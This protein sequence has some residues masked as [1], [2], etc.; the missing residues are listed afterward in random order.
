MCG[1]GRFALEA[2]QLQAAAR[3]GA[4]SRAGGDGRPR[5]AAEPEA[6]GRGSTRGGSGDQAGRGSGASE[7]REED[8][9]LQGQLE[10]MRRENF[11]PGMV[12]FILVANGNGKE[13]RTLQLRKAQWGLLP[14]KLTK[15][16]SAGDFFQKFNAREDNLEHVHSTRLGRQH[17]VVLF[18][19]F[20][21]WKK[22][23]DPL[24]KKPTKQPYYIYPKDGSVLRLAGLYETSTDPGTGEELTTFTI[25]T[26]AAAKSFSWLHHR[27]PAVLEDDAAVDA[28]L[29]ASDFS[30][31]TR[32]LLKPSEN[33]LDWHPVTSAM[34]KT[35]YQASDC[36]KPIKLK[37]EPSVL[38][39]WSKKGTP[40][41]T[42]R[43]GGV[44]D[45]TS[46]PSKPPPVQT[47]RNSAM[48]A[49]SKK[50]IS[51]AH[52]KNHGTDRG[53]N[54]GGNDDEDDDVVVIQDDTSKT[55]QAKAR[56]STDV[57]VSKKRP[58]TP[59]K[60]QPLSPFKSPKKTK[61]AFP[62]EKGQATLGAF[63]GKK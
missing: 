32:A 49:D 18:N 19:G 22:G 26:V 55:N 42:K 34:G 7:P 4:A 16:V 57:K 13:T 3:T 36:T 31:K 40:V 62:A 41:V 45:A 52:E 30:P 14:R 54:G 59:S 8:A 9:G 23:Q 5:A 44:K 35:S 37:S 10:G 6:D 46:V 48:P 17:C 47:P 56:S 24:S 27:M 43:G 50:E 63:F 58:L 29:S 38:S 12:A 1:R 53:G 60:S 20:Y 61:A 2:G 28:W 25:V 33:L 11:G 21:E 39:F 15:P 51:A